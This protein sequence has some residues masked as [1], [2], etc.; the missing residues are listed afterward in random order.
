MFRY[1][2]SDTERIVG[3]IAAIARE[4]SLREG[5][6]FVTGLRIC[7]GDRLHAISAGAV[8]QILE[9]LYEQAGATAEERRL[10]I[11][12]RHSKRDWLG[13]FEP[14]TVT[15][16]EWSRLQNDLEDTRH[17]LVRLMESLS[18]ETLA[19]EGAGMGT[20]AHLAYHLGAIRQLMHL[21]PPAG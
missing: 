13:S 16:E 8:L 1:R 2:L 15:E 21:V 6:N 20:I 7:L 19:E 9:R 4:P 3:Q 10:I 12:C 17:E 18:P 11:E 5:K 14:Q